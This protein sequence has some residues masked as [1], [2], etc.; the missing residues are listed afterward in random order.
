MS[1]HN[2]A[3]T[4]IIFLLTALIILPAMPLKGQRRYNYSY[5][6]GNGTIALNLNSNRCYSLSSTNPEW[7]NRPDDLP[8]TNEEAPPV[9]WSSGTY[10]YSKDTIIC[11][12]RKDKSKLFYFVIQEQGDKL[13][14]IRLTDISKNTSNLSLQRIL[15]NDSIIKQT[16]VYDLLNEKSV[17]Y[18][19]TYSVSK[20]NKSSLLLDVYDWRNGTKVKIFHNDKVQLDEWKI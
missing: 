14:A 5:N 15:Y 13:N 12:D 9:I 16:C 6:Y 19:R 20:D 17:F 4:R 18:V 3:T 7:L 1:S 8:L 10:Y 2:S 11:K